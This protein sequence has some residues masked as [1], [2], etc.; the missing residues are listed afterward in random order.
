MV[1]LDLLPLAEAEAL[2]RKADGGRKGRPGEKDVADLP[3]L[4]ERRPLA[5]DEVAAQLGVSGRQIAKA[6]R[7]QQV[8]PETADKVRAGDIS[9][10][11][12]RG[13]FRRLGR[14]T[15]RRSRRSL[16]VTSAR[17]VPG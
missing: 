13:S 12:G 16:S 2:A 9:L 8:D 15:R 11:G 7:V 3:H 5:R 10:S 14:W 17:G 6:K 1:G 4:S